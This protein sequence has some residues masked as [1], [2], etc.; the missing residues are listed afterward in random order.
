MYLKATG[1]VGKTAGVTYGIDLLGSCVGALF[2]SAFILPILGIIQTCLVMVSLNLFTLILI[3]RP[4][5][6]EADTSHPARSL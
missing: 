3:L 1:E 5:L 2:I 6:P 4:N